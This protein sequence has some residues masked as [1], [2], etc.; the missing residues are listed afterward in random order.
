MSRVHRTTPNHVLY[1]C[2]LH[3]LALIGLV[4]V[5]V[6]TVA[7]TPPDDTGPD[8][9]GSEIAEPAAVPSAGVWGFL[10]PITGEIT[11]SPSPEQ[12]EALLRL[13]RSRR[14][15]LSRSGAGLRVFPL[16]GGGIG[17]DLEERFQ[18]ATVIRLAPD[19][20]QTLDCVTDEAQVEALLENS[21]TGTE[22]TDRLAHEHDGATRAADM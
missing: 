10:D 20:T 16:D 17:I 15:A 4:A 12:I 14:S 6:P 11:S 22:S 1:L 13:S 9:T 2:L 21:S 18:S 5:A 3:G 19:G 8:S 7:Q